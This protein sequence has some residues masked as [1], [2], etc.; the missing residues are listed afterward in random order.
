LTR[1]GTA[2]GHAQQWLK[3]AGRNAVWEFAEMVRGDPAA[4]RLANIQGVGVLNA[5][6]LVP[7]IGRSHFSWGGDLPLS[8]ASC[9]VK[10]RLAN[11]SCW[12]SPNVGAN[13]LASSSRQRL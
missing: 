7:A 8:L 1:V 12:V 6:A 3:C 11:Q 13:V 10:Q 5:T 4:R 9:H 2:F